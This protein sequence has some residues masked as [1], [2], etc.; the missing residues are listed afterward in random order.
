MKRLLALTLLLVACSGS[1]GA[2]I[3]SGPSPEPT[4]TVSFAPE[5][6]DSGSERKV[7]SSEDAGELAD[8]STTQDS[9]SSDSGSL[10]DAGQDSGQDANPPV[11]PKRYGVLF[12]GS[13]G[14]RVI[15]PLPADMTGQAV[16][17]L[18][19]YFRLDASSAKGLLFS[20]PAFY[21]AV[22]TTGDHANELA[23]C[24]LDGQVCLYTNQAFAVGAWH[25]V[26]V[27]L[28]NGALCL[29]QDGASFGCAATGIMTFP[30]VDAT[31]GL[32]TSTR[33][34]FG[35]SAI[36]EGSSKTSVD[37]FRVSYAKRY[38]GVYAPPKHLTVDAD[39][40]L[41]LPLDEGAGP[42]SGTATLYGGASW[43]DVA[44]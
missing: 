15:S 18:E 40:K 10:A 38:A 31:P 5:P 32:N 9:G 13:A 14:Q 19:G 6:P 33:L 27:A 21:A 11:E 2:E 42:T 23:A 29:A 28:D 43:V 17:T 34:A 37:E 25:H 44:R 41:T 8:S 36:A 7:A 4:T 1:S 16:V 3:L 22:A 39:A 20:S 26:A 24:T 35:A 12:D 30:Q